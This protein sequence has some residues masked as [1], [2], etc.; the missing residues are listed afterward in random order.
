MK[1]A[2]MVNGKWATP[3]MSFTVT[4]TTSDS[5]TYEHPE[6]GDK[7]RT[8]FYPDSTTRVVTGWETGHRGCAKLLFG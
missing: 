8:E 3:I 5:Y 7:V 4:A 2:R 1:L 6:H